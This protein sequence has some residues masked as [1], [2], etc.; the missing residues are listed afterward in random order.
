MVS[1]VTGKTPTPHNTKKADS[2]FVLDNGLR[3]GIVTVIDILGV[4]GDHVSDFKF[5]EFQINI[6]LFTSELWCGGSAEK[7]FL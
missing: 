5:N 6:L 4:R 3:P 7:F 1:S 2:M